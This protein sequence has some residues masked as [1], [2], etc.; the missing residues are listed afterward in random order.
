MRDLHSEITVVQTIPAKLHQESTAS[1][2][3]TGV[4]GSRHFAV[5]HIVNVGISLE[6][7]SGS[8]KTTL[9]L[10][11][12]ADNSTYAAVTDAAY[13]IGDMVTLASGIF[14]VIDAAA[15]DPAVFNIGY[16]GPQRYSRVRALFTGNH[17]T[18]T[19]LGAVAIK[20]EPRFSG[21]TGIFP[22]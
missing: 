13:I 8:L 1:V 14:A 5:E 12:S 9:Y 20:G 22:A 6:T 17:S 16:R 2:N 7:L 4:D 10:E 15:E 18:G 19:P 21:T 3:G 11:D